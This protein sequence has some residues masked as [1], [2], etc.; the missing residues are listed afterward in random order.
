M[1]VI[2]IGLVCFGI[3][4][5]YGWIKLVNWIWPK[6]MEKGNEP[7]APSNP[8]IDAQR[9]RDQNDRWYDEYLSWMDHN[10]GG[11]PMN[12]VKTPEEIEFE[13]KYE[14]AQR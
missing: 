2:V 4:L 6:T 7:I 14:G 8:Y 5:I 1:I 9:R 11:M 3:A 13:K 10:N 12:K